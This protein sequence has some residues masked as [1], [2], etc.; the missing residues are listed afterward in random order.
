MVKSRHIAAE[1]NIAVR[2]NLLRR[3]WFWDGTSEVHMGQIWWPN[4]E[5]VI[6]VTHALN[7]NKVKLALIDGQ[8]PFVKA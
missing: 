7:E 5:V 3:D 6:K 2:D 4:I 1:I 8:V